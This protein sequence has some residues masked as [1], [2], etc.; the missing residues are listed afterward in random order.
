MLAHVE[1]H[2]AWNGISSEIRIIKAEGGGPPELLAAAAEGCDADLVVLGAYGHSQLREMLF[3][4]CT[5]SFLRQ[6]D[7]PVLMMH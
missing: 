3:G 4:G 5:Q 2:L 7:R 1:R 6:A